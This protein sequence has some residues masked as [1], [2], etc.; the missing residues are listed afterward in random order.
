MKITILYENLIFVGLKDKRV[1]FYYHDD[2]FI[3]CW[4]ETQEEAT[5]IFDICTP[6]VANT[7]NGNI[8]VKDYK[9]MTWR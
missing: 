6:S 2:C 9:I 5:I 8:K 4:F 7:G 1:E 3:I